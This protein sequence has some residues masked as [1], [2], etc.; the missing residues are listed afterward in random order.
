M[1]A[2]GH[3]IDFKERDKEYGEVVKNKTVQKY[4]MSADEMKDDKTNKE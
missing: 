2:Q 4:F 3:R 1:Q